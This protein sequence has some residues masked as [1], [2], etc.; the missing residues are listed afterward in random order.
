ML[1][2]Q[3]IE[4]SLFI[5]ITKK[6]NYIVINIDKSKINKYKIDN[7]SNSSL[8][9]VDFRNNNK[10]DKIFQYYIFFKKYNNYN[11]KIK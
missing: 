6:N 10:I 3:Y 5:I 2:N 11:N 1:S 7:N 8:I 4:S 9:V